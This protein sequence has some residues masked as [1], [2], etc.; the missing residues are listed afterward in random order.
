MAK[1]V[2]WIAILVA[3]NLTNILWRTTLHSEVPLWTL[4]VRIGILVL[5]LG[6]SLS[7]PGL[8]S[9]RGYLVALVALSAGF[10]RSL[11]HLRAPPQLPDVSADRRVGSSDPHLL[12]RQRVQ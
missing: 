3:S 2:A 6:L 4:A 11:P 8:R 7:L 1:A 9:L 5:L 12:R 10:L